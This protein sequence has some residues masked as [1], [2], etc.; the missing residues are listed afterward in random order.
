MIVG[1]R[2]F[3]NFGPA[4]LAQ[5]LSNRLGTTI[6]LHADGTVSD[7]NPFVDRSDA[8]DAIY[9]NG[10]RNAQGLTVQPATG[11]VWP[12]EFGEPSVRASSARGGIGLGRSSRAGWRS[13]RTWRAGSTVSDPARVRFV[14]DLPTRSAVVVIHRLQLGVFQRAVLAVLAAHTRLL[15][16]DMVGVP[17]LA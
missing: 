5:D 4:R 7:A 3:K 17:G 10:D 6:R 11:A 1:D 13:R 12:S 16:A 14:R 9:S 15:P 2:Q 8:Q